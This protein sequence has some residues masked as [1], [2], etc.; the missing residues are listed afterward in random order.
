MWLELGPTGRPDGGSHRSGA[1]TI[2]PDPIGLGRTGGVQCDAEENDFDDFDEEDFDDDFD[3]DFEEEF[4]EDLDEDLDEGELE[5]GPIEDEDEE[6]DDEGAAFD[7]DD[8]EIDDED[9]EDAP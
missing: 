2:A 3:D 9:F 5:E 1:A 7:S 8:E 4:D 6:V